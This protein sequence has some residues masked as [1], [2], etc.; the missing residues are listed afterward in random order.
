MPPD[1]KICI[2]TPFFRARSSNSTARVLQISSNV[3]V[4]FRIGGIGNIEAIFTGP[5]MQ[6]VRSRNVN[7]V[8]KYS[9]S[10]RNVC[11]PGNFTYGERVRAVGLY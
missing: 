6:S 9:P 11:I 7:P 3:R 5:F 10:R 1:Q 4:I 2:G 8:L